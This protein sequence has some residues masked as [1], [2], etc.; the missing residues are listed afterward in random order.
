MPCGLEDRARFFPRL[1]SLRQETPGYFD[2][3]AAGLVPL[4]PGCIP[5]AP[6]PTVTIVFCTIDKCA[7]MLGWPRRAASMF[8]GLLLEP[9][10]LR[11]GTH[12]LL[13]VPAWTSVAVSVLS[14]CT[15]CPA[16][17]L[18]NA[19]VIGCAMDGV[20]HHCV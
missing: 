3:P 18:A 20:T 4:S 2:A 12:L 13:P 6:M 19:L 14:G 10:C 7:W 11:H 17:L 5:N 15:N 8:A 16:F 1:D 9:S